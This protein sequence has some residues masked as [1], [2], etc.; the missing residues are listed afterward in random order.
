M[1]IFI[2]VFFF[3]FFL[4]SAAQLESTQDAARQTGLAETRHNRT[5]ELAQ[6]VNRYL[7]EQGGSAP[8]SLDT[9]AGTAGYQQALEYK[10]G[11]PHG[12]GPYLAVFPITR[13]MNTFSRVI[14]YMPPYD[15]SISSDDYLLSANNACGATDARVDGP[16]CGNPKGSY[17]VTDTIN[18]LS[19]ELSRERLQQQTTLKKFAQLYST[20]QIYPNPGTGD[21]GAVK[22][23]DL[24]PGYS[25]MAKAT[26]CT[27]IWKAQVATPGCTTMAARGIPMT[28]SAQWADLPL[29][30]DDLYTIWGTPRVYNFLSQ[31]RIA[32]YAEAGPATAP[33]KDEHNVP[34]I[35]ASQLDSRE[36]L[37]PPPP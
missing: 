24:I 2:V 27:G 4:T 5:V 25:P 28:C 8:V 35:V 20:Y 26:T 32:L 31:D 9:L 18:R 22:L 29:T 10:T 6:L 14:V 19:I 7:D 34:Y 37:A 30:C 11:G 15:G 3:V 17:W 13:E 16:W 12:D 21:G 36:S 1:P 23:I 33:W